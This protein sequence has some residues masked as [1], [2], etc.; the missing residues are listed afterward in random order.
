MVALQSIQVSNAQIARAFPAGLVAV[1]AGATAGIG[2]IALQNFAQ[3]T[4]KPRIY[5]VGRSEEACDRLGI[6][7]KKVNPG[8]EYIFIRSDIS[9]IRNV[10]DVCAKIKSRETAINVLFMSQGT[11][12]MKKVTDEGI[13]YLMALTYFGRLRFASNLLPLLQKSTSLRRV[14]S[15]FTGARE[16]KVY[17]TA[18][19]QGQ[20]A[21]IPLS[22]A[23]THSSTM[24]TL[25]LE[26]LAKK[27]PEVSFIHDFP[28][29]VNTNLI[30]SGDGAFMQVLKYTFK[31]TGAL[32]LSLRTPAVEVGERHTFYC[33][34]SRFPPRDDVPSTAAGV[35]LPDGVSAAL[36]VDGQPGSGMY[37]VDGQSES[38]D[39]SIVALLAEYMKDGTAE[40]LSTYTDSELQRVTSAASS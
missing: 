2:E 9:L 14:V 29:S 16:G 12:N 17:P 19:Q 1:F 34:S 30:R 33:T 38:A 13:N 11:L 23:R 22:A 8:G 26:S 40:K 24:M 36:G 10:D 4:T 15:A 37:S 31:I 7:L 25:G 3:H 32:G 35:G 6:D 28:G 20:E 39:S 5:I 27:A 21:N 18:W